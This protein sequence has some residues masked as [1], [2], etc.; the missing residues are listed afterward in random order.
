MPW[1][2][3]DYINCPG[4]W[5]GTWLLWLSIIYGNNNPNWLICFRG[6]ETTNQSLY[7]SISL[8]LLTI[9]T[10]YCY[11]CYS[12]VGLVKGPALKGDPFES[13][14]LQVA[15]IENFVW[16]KTGCQAIDVLQ[17]KV[18][19]WPLHPLPAGAM[20]PWLQ[21]IFWCSLLGRNTPS[22]ASL[23]WS[24]PR[25]VISISSG[26]LLSWWVIVL[27]NYHH[28]K[29]KEY[30]PHSQHW[31]IGNSVECGKPDDKFQSVNQG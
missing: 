14:I 9:P 13:L 27:I 17:K 21:S 20:V 6:V 12:S 15:C 24:S 26:S 4:W 28:E 1:R 16:L 31:S 8:T 18:H 30:P 10:L 25:V 7:H 2:K 23:Y 29:S 19:D 3:T 11:M 22:Q 5:F